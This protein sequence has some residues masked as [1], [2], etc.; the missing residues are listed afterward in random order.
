MC[1]GVGGGGGGGGKLGNEI[2]FYGLQI[3]DV[4]TRRVALSV[5]N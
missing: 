1:V 5:R 2:E 4:S 3:I